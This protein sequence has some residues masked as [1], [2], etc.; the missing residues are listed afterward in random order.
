M[1]E[2]R[3]SF[4]ADINFPPKKSLKI[5]YTYKMED[6]NKKKPQVLNIVGLLFNLN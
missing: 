5:Y 4:G 2:Y 3:L 6:L 1:N